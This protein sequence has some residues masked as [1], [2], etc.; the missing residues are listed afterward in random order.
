MVQ[1]RRHIRPPGKQGVVDRL[2]RVGCAVQ[3]DEDGVE[4][5]MAR[6]FDQSERVRVHLRVPVLARAAHMRGRHKAPI[7]GIAP[8]V[9][10]AANGPLDPAR[11]GHQDHAAVSADIL[12]HPHQAIA[13]AHQQEWNAEECQRLGITR[14]RHGRRDIKRRPGAGQ[15][16]GAFGLPQGGVGVVAVRQASRRFDRAAHGGQIGGGD[17]LGH[18]ALRDV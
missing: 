10:G 18:G 14:L 17:I 9:I 11:L 4:P 8:G 1:M 15:Q 16:R 6:H 2:E 12:E 7:M 13:P 3:V 5:D